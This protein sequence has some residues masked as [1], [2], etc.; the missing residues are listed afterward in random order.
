MSRDFSNSRSSGAAG[1]RVKLLWTLS[2]NY[3]PQDMIADSTENYAYA[4]ESHKI[5]RKIITAL[6]KEY[7]SI[8]AKT[9]GGE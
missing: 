3:Y 1:V 4:S 5:I 7:Q 9:M 8:C 2:S 6:C